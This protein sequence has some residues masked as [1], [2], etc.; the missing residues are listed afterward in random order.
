MRTV[1]QRVNRAQVKIDE[2][3]VASIEKGLC[4]LVGIESGDTE[5]DMEYTA[6]KICNL[7][8]F[9]DEKSFMNLDINDVQGEV[10]L[11]S[12]FT[13]L[14]DARKGR[15]P[16]F[17]D[18]EKSEKAKEIFDSLV[19]QME[20]FLPCRIKTGVFQAMMEVSII[21]DGPVTLLLDSR[22]II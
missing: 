12:Q 10:L 20:G 13:L 22:K 18:A 5:A 9:D 11:V 17:S 8:I 7:R 14:G 19:K 2:S 16:S 1:I 6:R 4:C 15:R 21:N 3:V